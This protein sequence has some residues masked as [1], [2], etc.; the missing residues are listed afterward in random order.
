MA[1]TIKATN[2]GTP[3]GTGNITLDRPIAGDGSNLTGIAGAWTF[4]SETVASNSATISITSGITSTYDLY[5]V[6][7]TN[8][9]PA[10]TDTELDMLVSTDGGSSY[11]SLIHI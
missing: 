2:I 7:I 1:S 5:M 10:T 9:D 8:L 4:I 6:V 3:D 11:L